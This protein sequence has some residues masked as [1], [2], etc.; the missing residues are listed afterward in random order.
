MPPCLAAPPAAAEA[1][2]WPANN[3]PFLFIPVRTTHLFKKQPKSALRLSVELAQAVGALPGK[4]SDRQR[5][6]LGAG[7]C[8][9]EGEAVP[10]STQAS[11]FALAARVH[12]VG[13]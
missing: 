1:C 4:E 11:Q 13:K 3:K 2:G 7:A 5:R 10:V 12:A 8:G 6:V 9:K